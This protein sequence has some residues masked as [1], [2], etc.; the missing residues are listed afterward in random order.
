MKFEF[1]FEDIKSN[2]MMDEARTANLD[3]FFEWTKTAGKTIHDICDK[4]ITLARSI[5]GIKEFKK[6]L[7][8]ATGQDNDLINVVLSLEKQYRAWI[9]EVLEPQKAN[10]IYKETKI[11]IKNN[12]EPGVR[13]RKLGSTNKPKDNA[14]KITKGL[15]FKPTQSQTAMS[16]ETSAASEIPK[17]KK[18]YYTPTG[19]PRGRRPGQKNAPKDVTTKIEPSDISKISLSNK[20]AVF[21]SL[22]SLLNNGIRDKHFDDVLHLEI[23]QYASPLF[24]LKIRNFVLYFINT[25]IILN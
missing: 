18:K 19:N 22:K 1:L 24:S 15:D 13:G 4:D 12:S 14:D 25:L 7:D 20:E 23:K 2:E 10:K 6:Y 9:N 11:W 8:D 21:E 17:E 3:T 5:P 16:P